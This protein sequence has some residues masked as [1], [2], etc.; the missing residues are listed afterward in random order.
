[1]WHKSLSTSFILLLLMVVVLYGMVYNIEAKDT[2]YTPHE[3]I[4]IQSDDDFTAENGVIGG[5]GTATGPYIIEGLEIAFNTSSYIP[6]NIAIGNTTAYVIVRNCKLVSS[7]ESLLGMGSV[8][9]LSFVENVRF[10]NITSTDGFVTIICSNISNSVFKH[11][12]INFMMLMSSDNNTISYCKFSPGGTF[13]LTLSKNN[14]IDN[15]NFLFQPSSGLLAEESSNKWSNNYWKYYSGQDT[16]GD[17]I[18]DTP[19]TIPNTK[20][21]DNYPKM[22]LIP[23]A[24]NLYGYS[25]EKNHLPI[26]DFYWNPESPEVGKEVQFF[27]DSTDPDG[28]NIVSWYWDFGDNSFSDKKNPTHYY[29]ETSPLGYT[30]T[31]T[32]TDSRGASGSTSKHLMVVG[33]NITNQKPTIEIT[34]P[35]KGEKVS[36]KVNI[37]GTASDP[38]GIISVIQVRIS[39]S[40]EWH[41]ATTSDYNYTTGNVTWYYLW[42]SSN[43]IPG[44]VTIRAKAIDFHGLESN[45]ATITVTVEK[46][47]SGGSG[48]TPGFETVLTLL[49]ITVVFM[50]FRK[51]R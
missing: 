36:G 47:S 49:A 51:K 29:N 17:G 20:D 41:N 37:T 4:I 34:Y 22:Q 43:V 16:N 12:D 30:V 19:Y 7:N 38:D 6:Y 48:G 25:Y 21:K 5:N 14:H 32:V 13:Y 45:E 23:N 39:G 3:A 27:D 35:K 33:E 28:D 46:T 31:L 11:C 1:M 44:E 18:G 8:I 42:D 40:N 10:E 24:G 9:T 26:A 15:N 2:Y 50:F